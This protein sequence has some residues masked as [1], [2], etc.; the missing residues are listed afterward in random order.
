MII[1]IQ[2]AFR[3]MRTG[4]SNELVYTVKDILKLLGG[5]A[6]QI[7]FNPPTGKYCVSGKCLRDYEYQ[8]VLQS[9]H[10]LVATRNN[11][12]YWMS[13]EFVRKY[14]AC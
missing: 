12:N 11:H 7:C 14:Q 1:E 9:P 10:L 4:R 8:S 6:S 3:N 13:L 2:L 5:S